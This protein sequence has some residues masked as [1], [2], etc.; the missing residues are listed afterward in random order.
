MEYNE[1]KKEEGMEY[2]EDKRRKEGW[3][4]MNRRKEGWNIM[5]IRKGR[6]KGIY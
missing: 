5:K 2:T 4:I 1:E 6:R 3:N